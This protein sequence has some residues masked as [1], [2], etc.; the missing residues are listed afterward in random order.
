MTVDEVRPLAERWGKFWLVPPVWILAIVDIESTFNPDTI[1]DS[2]RAAAR[3]NAWGLMQI[4]GATA[5]DLMRWAR[6]ALLAQEQRDVLGLWRADTLRCLLE[7]NL[8]VCLGASYLHRLASRWPRFEL[9]AAAYHQGPG[10]VA[11]LL[12][13]HPPKKIPDDL[14]PLGREY[15]TRALHALARHTPAEPTS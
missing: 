12:S 8:N 14:P 3:G 4:T 10:G 2:P 13:V 9:V 11:R 15:V 7:P 6:P 5:P 1:N